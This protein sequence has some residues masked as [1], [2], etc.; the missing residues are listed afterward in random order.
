MMILNLVKLV[1]FLSVEAGLSWDMER[2]E[3]L[4]RF[5][6]YGN[7]HNVSELAVNLTDTEII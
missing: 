6:R 1:T 5:I 2:A 7:K 3:L 4:S